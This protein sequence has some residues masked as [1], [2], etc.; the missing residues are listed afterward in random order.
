MRLIKYINE[1]KINVSEPEEV[2][3]ILRKDCM[4]FITELKRTGFKD[5]FFYR[6]HGYAEGMITKKRIRDNRR[7]K[8]MGPET[9]DFLDWAFKK[10][11]GW[12]AR[13]NGIFATSKPKDAMQYGEP[14]IFFPIGKY[15][16]IWSP[17]VP[18]LYS[19]I[20]NNKLH[21]DNI[22]ETSA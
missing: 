20:D 18:D 11:F 15:K 14:F 7:P 21:L 6:G 10:K 19:E 8:D 9:S 5:N 1:T 16:Y 2:I 3:D 13:S 22:D 17:G 12:A 4:P